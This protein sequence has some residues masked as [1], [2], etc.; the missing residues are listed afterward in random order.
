MQFSVFEPISVKGLID[1][2]SKWDSILN[3]EW[4]IPNYF[5]CRHTGIGPSI[6]VRSDPSSKPGAAF[7]SCDFPRLVN[8]DTGRCGPHLLAIATR[9]ELEIQ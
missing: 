7:C 4:S 2:V 9:L 8:L 3:S 6:S 1:I 5:G